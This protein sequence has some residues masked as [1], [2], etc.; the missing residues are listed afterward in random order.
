[1][2]KEA[3]RVLKVDVALRLNASEFESADTLPTEMQ[4]GLYPGDEP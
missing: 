2:S 1:M 3:A 4:L